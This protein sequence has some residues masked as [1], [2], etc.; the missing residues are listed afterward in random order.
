LDGGD[1]IRLARMYSDNPSAS[2]GGLLPPFG[3]TPILPQEQALTPAMRRVALA[4]TRVGQVSDPVRVGSAY[5]I[6]YLERIIPAEGADFDRLRPE[7]EL[8]VRKRLIHIA[9]VR[10][11]ATLIQDANIRF[12]NP[13]L[14]EQHR[15]R[16]LNIEP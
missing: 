11:L 5:H 16:E 4:M 9:S 1:F 8:A 2:N 7:L 12:E 3:E 13:I 14:A 10:M 15:Q 6:L